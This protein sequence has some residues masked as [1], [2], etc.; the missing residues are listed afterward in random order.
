VFTPIIIDT[1]DSALDVVLADAA[2][3]VIGHE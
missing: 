2:A 3:G 1:I